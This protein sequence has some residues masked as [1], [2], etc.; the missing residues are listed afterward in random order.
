VTSLRAVQL[1]PIESKA[2][3]EQTATELAVLRSTAATMDMRVQSLLRDNVRLKWGGPDLQM[4]QRESRE[5]QRQMKSQNEK[6]REL[7]AREEEL[8]RREQAVDTIDQVL[9]K[10]WKLY[11][12]MKSAK[13]ETETAKESE[14]LQKT[15]T[16]ASQS[17]VDEQDTIITELL[18]ERDE[19]A[20]RQYDLPVQQ[21][22]ISIEDINRDPVRGY[23]ACVKRLH[24]EAVNRGCPAS[25]F[26]D[27]HRMTRECDAPHLLG[28]SIPGSTAVGTWRQC[29][30]RLAGIGAGREV[31][32][33]SKITVISDATTKGRDHLNGVVLQSLDGTGFHHPRTIIT[34]TLPAM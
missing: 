27:I 14:K 5:L 15:K 28:A 1:Q 7:I 29:S 21:N 24:V 30:T 3:E 23:P 17:R 19:F 2:R 31:N 33:M 13:A 11:E 25:I 20:A 32:E 26:P 16:R 34:W 8:V 9:P 4:R 18:F 10:R 12:Q 6:E 22:I